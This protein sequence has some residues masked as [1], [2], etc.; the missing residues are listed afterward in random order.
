MAQGKGGVY[1]SFVMVRLAKGNSKQ[2]PMEGKTE[3]TGKGTVS[4]VD[5]GNST[6]CPITKMKDPIAKFFGFEIIQPM[7]MVRLATQTVETTINGKKQTVSKLTKMGTTGASRSITVKFTALQT[8]GGK[9]VASVKVAMPSSH[10]F[11]DMVTELMSGS[12]T[13]VIA[14]I[15]SPSGSTMSFK[16][17]YSSKKKASGKK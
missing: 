3:K 7:D 13:G 8:I 15:V 5:K 11:K 12:Q 2:Y 1:G 10:T 4:G 9:Q 14:Q 17:A 16:A 6:R